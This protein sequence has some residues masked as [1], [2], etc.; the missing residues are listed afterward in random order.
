MAAAMLLMLVAEAAL[1]PRVGPGMLAL[2]SIPALVAGWY[3]GLVTGAAVGA[4]CFP[5]AAAAI[6][7][8]GTRDI[9]SV[10]EQAGISTTLGVAMIGAI[11]G[12]V[13]DLGA[14]LRRQAAELADRTHQYEA[15]LDGMSDLGEGFLLLD[16]VRVVYANDAYSRL[17]GYSQEELLALPSIIALAPP[18]VAPVVIAYREQRLQGDKVPEHYIA[19]LLTKT[20]GRIDV[21]VA[22]KDLR[23]GDRPLA[24]TLVRDI[25]A[26]L[27]VESERESLAEQVIQRNRDLE[28]SNAELENFAYVASHDLSEPLRMIASHLQL[29]QRRYGDKLDADADDFIGFAVDGATRLQQMIRDLLEYS[30]VGRMER[31][32]SHVDC[33]SVARSVLETLAP[34]IE[35]T[36]AVVKVDELPTIY[37]DRGHIQSLFQNLLANALKFRGPEPPRVHLSAEH[38]MSSWRFAVEDNGIGI[39]EEHRKRIF[40]MFRRLHSR[41]E[42]EGSGVGLAICKK[43]VQRY[44]G[45]IWVLAAP[46]R[47]TIFQFSIP[48]KR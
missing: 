2:I 26:R 20:G 39:A 14:K 29:L 36:H 15:M 10:V 31:A 32:W 33:N 13:S 3:G 23:L 45:D 27:R 40:E 5:A 17:T 25:T 46:E 22:R 41:D 21:E 38:V 30:R 19:A 37:A 47:G 12:R 44:G 6:W 1:Y 11:L 48:D 35:E 43:V 18:D 9:G 4:I 28:M 34:R 24:I 7:F 8:T 42:Y 16:G